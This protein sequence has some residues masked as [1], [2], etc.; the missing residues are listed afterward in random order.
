MTSLLD[1]NASLPDPNASEERVEVSSFGDRYKGFDPSLARKLAGLI[2]QAHEQFNQ[3]EDL[4][5]FKLEEVY[6]L[7]TS[8]AQKEVPFG[9]VASEASSND[10]FVVF[11]GTRL[12]LEWFKDANIQLVSYKDG[13]DKDDREIDIEVEG[14]KR[15]NQSSVTIENIDRNFGFVTAGFR[16]IYISLRQKLIEALNR[17]GISPNSRIFVTGHS[18]GGALATLAIPDI[19]KNT[20]F[21]DPGQVVLYTFASPRCGDRH[22]ATNFQNLGVKHWRIA[23]TEDVVTMMPFPTGNVTSPAPIETPPESTV[24]NEATKGNPFFQFL[25]G[26]FDSKRRRMP[27]YAHTGIPVYFTIHEGALERHH[28]LDNIYMLGISQAPIP[29]AVNVVGEAIDNITDAAS[30]H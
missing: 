16:G 11:R 8:L 3:R 27:D 30:N 14:V 7:T 19:L 6:Q 13:K 12:F 24:T 1:L 15:K 23:N 2:Q 9:F 20:P 17:V 10:I 22:F 4:Q 18:L 21:K 25:K 28:N 26:F 5:N 29:I